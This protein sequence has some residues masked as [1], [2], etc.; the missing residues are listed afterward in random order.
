LRSTTQIT[1]SGGVAKM[2]LNIL[3]N[4]FMLTGAV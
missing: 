3:G 1:Y 4:W 2:P